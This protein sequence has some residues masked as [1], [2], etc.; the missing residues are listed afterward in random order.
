VSRLEDIRRQ[1]RA[2]S[3]P[4]I[5]L[6]YLVEL[7]L[8]VGPALAGGFGAAPLTHAELRAWQDDIGIRLTPW[9][10]RALKRMSG[11]YVAELSKAEATDRPAPFV[12]D[13][14]HRR[15]E[16]ARKIDEVF[17]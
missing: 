5:S 11:E 4:H 10:A 17:G 14:R 7:F 1:G 12:P 13:F 6:P 2:P 8:E 9:E 15:R 16:V 3:L